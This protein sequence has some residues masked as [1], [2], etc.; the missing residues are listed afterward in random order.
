MVKVL[1]IISLY[2]IPFLLLS[3]PL[4]GHFKKVKVYETF[5]EGA[6][7]GFSTA[8]MIIP[9]LVAML[10]AIG[11]FRSSGAMDILTGFLAPVTEAVKMPAE[12]L[13]MAIM[14]SLS[15]G[16]AEGMMAELI[17]THGPDSLIG[18]MSSVLM[19]ST[20]TT[21]YIIAVYFGSIGV[22]KTRH[23]IPAGLL[24]DFASIVAAVFITNLVFGG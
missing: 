19:G 13:P 6:K 3:I 2:A 11:M 22:K 18:R 15:G 1:E 12:V 10:V 17:A 23:A 20:E 9:F 8:I 24:A 16:G 21:F 14:R 5:V 7:E 4:Y